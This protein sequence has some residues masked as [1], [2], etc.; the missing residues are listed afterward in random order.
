MIYVTIT[1][2]LISLTTTFLICIRLR[3]MSDATEAAAMRRIQARGE[4]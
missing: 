1:A 2:I 3:Q 4:Q